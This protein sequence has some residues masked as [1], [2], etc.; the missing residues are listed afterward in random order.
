MEKI[1]EETRETLALVVT[2]HVDHGKS[3]VIGRLLY[4]TGSLPQG[5]VDR[6]RAISQE[7]GQPFEFAFLLDAFEEERKQGITIDITRLQFKTDKRDY[8]IID[9]PGHKEFL[10]N[11]ISG[12]SDAEAAFLTVDA[13]RGVEEQTKR[14][15]HML[16][17]LG[18]GRVGVL[19]NKMD[20]VNYEEKVFLKIRDELSVFLLNLGLTPGPFVPMSALMG[21]N[22]LH[23]S[24]KLPWY[25]GPTLLGALDG[26]EK[27]HRPETLRFPIQ[28][29][30]KF[31]D[32]R[33]IAGRLESGEIREGD[34]ILISPGGKTAKV[35]SLAYW[36][37]KDAKKTASAGESIGITVSDE[38]FN[39][40]GEI[41]SFKDDP[42]VTTGLFRASIFWMGKKPLTVGESY[43]LKLA[44]ESSEA[45]VLEIYNLID[46]VNLAPLSGGTEVGFNEVAE[47]L[48][49]TKKPL[50]LDLFSKHKVTGRFV[51]VDGYDVSGGG[52]VTEAR[53]AKESLKGFVNGEIIA[54]CEVF[55][56]YLYDLS[57]LKVLKRPPEKELYSKG[58]AAPIIGKSYR[59][60]EDFDVIIFRDKVAVRIR[61]GK[62][63]DIMGLSD[64]SYQ[65]KPLVNGRGFSLR[66]ASEEEWLRLREA[67]GK[68]GAKDDAELAFKYLDFN[69]YRMIAF[70]E[71][72]A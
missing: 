45:R 46:S 52:I 9:A 29:V 17:L 30:Y 62:V 63:F 39:Q 60:P 19:V 33:I 23:P 38:F 26:L 2:G 10:K 5:T 67:F 61:E 68:E 31:D 3:T 34:E 24:P 25:S 8:L 35:T 1:M 64:Y 20:L 69:T 59:Y 6:V 28:D 48:I 11:M 71:E 43:K 32:R 51:I 15:A 53:E 41:I 56:E 16:S 14:H 42:P 27:I 57:S 21:E 70:G 55:E 4:D 54:R 18:I 37:S 40:R 7:T 12:A 49:S 58:D 36:L 66:A 44:T 22:V 47:V 72:R 50:A 13:L 65:G